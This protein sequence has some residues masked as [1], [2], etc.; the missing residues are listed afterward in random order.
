MN[1]VFFFID[2][3]NLYHSIDD[4]AKKFPRYNR[5]KWLNLRELSNSFLSKSQ[6]LEDVYYFSALATWNNEKTHKHEIYIKALQ[7]TNV[8]IVMEKF[9]RKSI[10][11]KKCKSKIFKP[12]EKQTDVNIATYLFKHA[13]LGSYDIAYILTGDSDI[14]PAVKAVKELFPT[15][16]IN[17]IIPIAR[18]ADELKSVCDRHMKMKEHHLKNSRFP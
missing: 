1:R 5:Y 3:F 17:L 6:K 12:E 2:G 4:L 13:V 10:D 18:Q 7:S 9:K 16:L 11:C 15:K 14:I 8:N